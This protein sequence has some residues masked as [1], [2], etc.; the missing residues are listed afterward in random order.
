M[1]IY[2]PKANES[3]LDDKKSE[4]SS[5]SP[6]MAQ[7]VSMK[8]LAKA[9]INLDTCNRLREKAFVL[10]GLPGELLKKKETLK[11]EKAYS[12]AVVKKTPMKTYLVYMS[13]Q[14]SEPSTMVRAVLRK[15]WQD[16]SYPMD[17]VLRRKLWLVASGTYAKIAKNRDYYRC[18]CLI[19]DKAYQEFSSIITLDIERTVD[20]SKKPE[21]YE[22]LIRILTNYCK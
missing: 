12:R 10:V 1:S 2:Q 19:K 21:I 9:V 16:S 17:P 11:K 18:L 5:I 22:K 3:V 15:Y 7:K 20:S 8:E 14:L 13:K 6:E 4:T